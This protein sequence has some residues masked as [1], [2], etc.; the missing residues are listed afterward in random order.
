MACFWIKLGLYLC[1]AY[2]RLENEYF[3]IVFFFPQ[4]NLFLF[5]FGLLVI[6]LFSPNKVFGNKPSVNWSHY[7]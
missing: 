3:F 1:K 7:T 4:L 2:V 5:V 6:Q